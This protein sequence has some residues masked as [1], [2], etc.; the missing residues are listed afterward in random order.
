MKKNCFF[1][2]V[3]FLVFSFF[4]A[5][6]SN[7]TQDAYVFE[8]VSS[9]RNPVYINIS[10]RDGANIFLH[11][12]YATES[13][14]TILPGTVD[15][16]R[17]NYYLFYIDTLSSST[18]DYSYYGKVTLTYTSATTA[19]STVDFA[20][21]VYR[22]VLYACSDSLSNPD[23]I[24]AKKGA[25][26]SAYTIADLRTVKDVSFYLSS[27]YLTEDG[28]A[29]ISLTSSWNLPSGW[30]TSLSGNSYVSVGIYD[31]ST[32]APLSVNDNNMNPHVLSYPVEISGNTH[33]SNFRFG[34]Y[35]FP[36]GTY[37]LIV[38]FVNETTGESYEYNDVIH[39]LSNQ[40]SYAN[41]DI[42]YILDTPPVAPSDFAVS[43]TVPTDAQQMNYL[44]DFT[45]TDNANN[46]TGFEIQIADI[47]DNLSN[48]NGS[49][50]IYEV[51]SDSEW[52][53][54]V[55]NNQVT[56]YTSDNYRDYISHY[57]AYF[58]SDDFDPNSYSLLRNNDHV[59]FYLQLGKRYLAR[60]RSVNDCGKSAWSYAVFDD[61]TCRSINLFRITYTTNTGSEFLFK[62]QIPAGVEIDT[63]TDSG[64]Q[65]WY[66]SEVS[67]DSS[68]NVTET[69]KYPMTDDNCD[70]YTGHSN[71]DLIGYYGSNPEDSA[72]DWHDNDV[73]LFGWDA[74]L[75]DVYFDSL[76]AAE[77]S[78]NKTQCVNNQYLEISKSDVSTLNWGLSSSAPAQGVTEALNRYE[79]VD[80]S[81]VRSSTLT[82]VLSGSID[83]SM[84]IL[85]INVQGLANDYYIMRFTGNKD[86]K[87]FNFVVVFKLKD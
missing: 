59:K 40:T 44:A 63:P 33:L 69:N 29:D 41:I 18:S 65:A 58:S 74:Y 45:W 37:S 51:S 47:S 6:C 68:G 31:I 11:Q 16:T 49:A 86:L 35:G 15:G 5:S 25:C 79:S 48:L 83:L 67:Y 10:S 43:A 28:Y 1:D 77:G 27:A 71:L 34:N 50:H 7:I 62:S 46:E 81:V 84:N 22:F 38:A 24:A 8:N 19:T 53:S 9:I 64:W 75:N 2:F 42:P 39:I 14:R 78:A 57:Y 76:T 60:I 66:I 3:L 52:N 36:A 72:Y 80:Y 12:D 87:T 56:A 30:N 70:A 85:R 73:L 55:S 13:A 23:I 61:G 26:M 32:G 20:D 82:A 17:L 21:S 54:T 4:F